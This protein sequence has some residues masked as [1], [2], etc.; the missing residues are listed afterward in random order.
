M[1][2][3]NPFDEKGTLDTSGYDQGSASEDTVL[4]AAK[5]QTSEAE[6]AE[7]PSSA[8]Y[9]ADAAARRQQSQ[10]QVNRT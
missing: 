1:S 9:A 5:D 10:S 4:G 2:A 6:M 7:K 8:N 3:V